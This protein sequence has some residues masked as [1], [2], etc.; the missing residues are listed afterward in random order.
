MTVY[1]S[2][3]AVKRTLCTFCGYGCEL[4][5]VFDDFGVKGVEYL[6]ETPNQGRLCPRGSACVSYLNHPKRLCVPVEM[7]NTETGNS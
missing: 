1:R 7:V 3:F 5:I 2:P 6:K 4:G